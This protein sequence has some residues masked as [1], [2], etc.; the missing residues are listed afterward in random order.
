MPIYAV[1]VVLGAVAT[2]ATLAGVLA[3]PPH[4]G[5]IYV[6]GITVDFFTVIFGYMIALDMIMRQPLEAPEG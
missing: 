5:A 6:S 3:D 4:A 1:F 2:L